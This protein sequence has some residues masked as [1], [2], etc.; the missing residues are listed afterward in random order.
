MGILLSPCA[1]V[2]GRARV[3]A[4][5]RGSHVV[6]REHKEN[7]A[8]TCRGEL[9]ARIREERRRFRSVAIAASLPVISL[10]ADGVRMVLSSVERNAISELGL[11]QIG[12]AHV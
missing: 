1:R 2:S 5:P 11:F 10:Q 4:S 12:R 6:A 9:G 7:G 8:D 3:S